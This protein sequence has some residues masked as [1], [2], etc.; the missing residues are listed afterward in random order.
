MKYVLA[1]LLLTT[2]LLG[3]RK[4]EE[5]PCTRTP[6]NTTA[7]TT[8]EAMVLSYLS[9]NG[10]TNALELENSGMYYV[11]DAPGN[12]TKPGMCTNVNVRYTGKFADNRVFD[13]APGSGLTVNTANFTLGD[14]IEAWKRALPLI[15]EGGKLRL[16]VP[17]SLGYGANGVFDSRTG[18]FIIPSN[19]ML[20]F[21]LELVRTF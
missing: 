2:A 11:I 10:I 12:N 9:V 3:C 18:L 5:A 7:S 16:F 1:S 4:E 15:G 6:G 13:P 21:E 8:E 17:P 14:L 19:A 20:V